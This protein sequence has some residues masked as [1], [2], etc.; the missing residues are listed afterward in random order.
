VGDKR[1]R[2]SKEFKF[3]VAIEAIKGQKQVAELAKEFGVHPQQ[4]ADWKKELLE[5][6][7]NIFASSVDGDK[8][9]VEDERDTLYRAVGY[10]KIQIDWLKKSLGITRLPNEEP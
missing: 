9:Q 2:R 10:Q 7:A 4:I 3:K 8:K 6:G 5:H 1:V